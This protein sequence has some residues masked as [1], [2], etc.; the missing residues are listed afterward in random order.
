MGWFSRITGRT[1]EPGA[2][3]L[4][5]ASDFHGSERTFRKF[6]NAA[7]YYGA[8]VLVMGGDIVGKLAIPII[9]EGAGRYRAYLMGKTEHLESEEQLN[10]L[11]ERLDTLGYY[12]RIMDADEFRA[13]KNDKEAV[14]S[15]FRDLALAR[16]LSWVDLAETRLS[17]T[18]VKCYIIGGNDDYPEVLSALEQAATEHVIYCEN[19]P[20]EIDEHHTMF[21]FGYSNPTPWNTPR[22]LPDEQIAERLTQLLDGFP[23]H[24]QSIFNIHVP[25]ADSGLDTCPMLDWEAD[26]P[27]QIVKGGQPV[28]YGAGSAAVRAAIE[29]H[30]PQ[31][32]LHG[33]IHESGAV[34]KIGRTTSINPGSEYGEGVLRGCL[35]TLGRDGVRGQQMTAG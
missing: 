22:E 11:R 24:R 23:N 30:Q 9:R 7:K 21:S 26:P 5:F 6:V 35:V 25:P 10:G 12:S 31:L 29:R 13:I 18:G 3:K 27:R 16:V 15:L 33:H 14:E 2:T 4:F 28:L 19:K 20:V 1:P 32:S 8:T 17:G 34:V